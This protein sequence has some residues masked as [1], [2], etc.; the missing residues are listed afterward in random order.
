[1]PD[2]AEKLRQMLSAASTSEGTQL[3][4]PPTIVVTGGKGGVGATTVTINLAAAIAQAGR[5]VVV[6]DAA[7]EADTV[8]RLNLEVEQGGTLDDVLNGA[9][10][11]V[12]ALVSGPGGISLLANPWAANTIADRSLRSCDRLLEYLQLPNLPADV[13]VFDAGSG[14]TPWMRR[15]WQRADLV[16]VVTTPDDDSVMDSYATIKRGIS[17]ESSDLRILVNQ[18]CDTAT[19]VDIQSRLAA[20][21]RRFLGRTIA[22]APLLPRHSSE[23]VA[24]GIA[25]VVWETPSS[26]FGRSV[27]QLGRFATD[28]LAQ[29]NRV[30]HQPHQLV[31]C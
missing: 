7:I 1:M 25:P 11:A 22:R 21:C 9:S 17:E 2:Q 3:A 18:A 28:V 5:R 20:A 14:V 27:N 23:C 29:V 4:L 10:T 6:V 31:T 26:P 16:L 15:L 30:P 19:A 13:L 8:R 24:G 12:D